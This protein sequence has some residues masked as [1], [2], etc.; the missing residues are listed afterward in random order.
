MKTLSKTIGALVLAGL[1]SCTTTRY[2]GNQNDDDVYY[3]PS[4]D[5]YSQSGT[6]SNTSSNTAPPE[7]YTSA[8][9]NSG[10]DQD[11]DQQNRSGGNVTNN[12]YDI[13]YD[14]DDYYDYAYASR[15][16]RFHSPIYSYGYYDPWYT[17][18]YWY[19]YDPVYY[20]SSIYLGYSWWY[21]SPWN[22][23]FGWNSYSGWNFGWSWGYSPYYY[24]GCGHGYYGVN[25]Y[26]PYAYG[27]G[28]SYWNGYNNG[29]WNGY[30]DGL[31]ASNNY[32]YNSYDNNSYYYGNRS[33]TSYNGNNG[34]RSF[35]ENYQESVGNEKAFNSKFADI[36]KDKG[37]KTEPTGIPNL[38]SEPKT[39]YQSLPA[40]DHSTANP[41]KGKGHDINS[42]S[43]PKGL[44]QQGGN[45]YSNTKENTV[46]GSENPIGGGSKG[47]LPNKNTD[48]GKTIENDNS[49]KQNPKDQSNPPVRNKPNF[50]N[51]KKE[52][53][54][55]SPEK[56]SQ[57]KEKE[58]NRGS[59]YNPGPSP[60]RGGSVEPKGNK[61]YVAPKP[62]KSPRESSLDFQPKNNNS[63]PAFSKGNHSG[64]TFSQSSKGNTSRAG[65]S[66]NH[67]GAAPSGGKTRR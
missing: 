1:V 34:Q 40:K 57:P 56:Y 42:Y 19:T 5:A 50:E 24:G 11:S 60:N 29:Y 44:N 30:Y 12:Y 27:Y 18:Y 48:F 23:S 4:E 53:N 63:S 20:G 15:I 61:T 51:V 6:S 66:V 62:N 59:N 54:S 37:N 33:S 16:R 41:D 55:P 22:W 32:Y 67:S 8:S 14:Y 46:K 52:Y 21:P 25:Y 2:A 3:T 28:H 58:N 26:N 36:P 39:N 31:Y 13:D 65:S 7:D 43:T 47:N 35:A 10:Q 45:K 9:D 49:P 17:N 38:S 64:K